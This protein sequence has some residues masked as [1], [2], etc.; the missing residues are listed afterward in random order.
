MHNDVTSVFLHIDG[1]MFL[2]VI[3]S[4]WVKRHLTCVL[5]HS[6]IF[7]QN[8]CILPVSYLPLLPNLCLVT[9]LESVPSG[10]TV[11]LIGVGFCSVW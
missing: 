2:G 10:S 1:L 8:S 6:T 7:A 9:F 5:F 11:D 3:F 4:E